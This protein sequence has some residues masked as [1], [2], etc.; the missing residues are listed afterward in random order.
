MKQEPEM[1][2]V[3]RDGKIYM[4]PVNPPADRIGNWLK[5]VQRGLEEMTAGPRQMHAQLDELDRLQLQRVR[6]EAREKAEAVAR[7]EAMLAEMAAMRQ[8]V[9]DANAREKQMLKL[10]KLSVA[11]AALTF[12]VAV[13]T[14]VV[15]IIIA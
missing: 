12:I 14:I 13:V 2:V 1:H 3:K 5:D 9:L 10:T 15:A 4:E 8:S 11:I 7:E 6:H